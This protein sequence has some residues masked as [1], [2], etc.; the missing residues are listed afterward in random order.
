MQ[1]IYLKN[2]KFSKIFGFCFI[3]I[4]ILFLNSCSAQ[5]GG[6]FESVENN[7]YHHCQNVIIDDIKY[8]IYEPS[9]LELISENTT[10]FNLKYHYQLIDKENVDVWTLNFYQS[11]NYLISPDD[12]NFIDIDS[13]LD[14]IIPSLNKYE[15]L[16]D[17]N[18]N[19]YQI[20]EEVLQEVV[21][22]D[23]NVECVYLI[24]LYVPY[25]IKCLDTDDSYTIFIPVNTFFAYKIENNVIIDYGTKESNLDYQ[26]FISY[27]NVINENG[28]N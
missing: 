24:T 23:E 8:A 5:G 4:A 20:D 14:E 16:L 18:F 26:K 7:E 3:L 11:I 22:D 1:H 27:S 17:I 19:R 12:V 10:N 28:G 21:V 13:L 25:F 2:H 15:Q 9:S 6:F